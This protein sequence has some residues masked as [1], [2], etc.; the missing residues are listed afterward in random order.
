MIS[1]ITRKCDCSGDTIVSGPTGAQA[2][3]K[4]GSGWSVC[5]YADTVVPDQLVTVM[6]TP[7]DS[8]FVRQ[9]V[10]S[11]HLDGSFHWG[12]DLGNGFWWFYVNGKKVDGSAQWRPQVPTG[13]YEIDLVFWS[14]CDQPE[15]PIKYLIHHK[16]G[17][18]AVDVLQ[19][20]DGALKKDVVSLG[21]YP[22]DSGSYVEVTDAIGDTPYPLVLCGNQTYYENVKVDTIT[23]K[24]IE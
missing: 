12:R 16:D 24:Q 20:F 10:N 15:L 17:V 4:Q 19:C 23:F 6:V 21:V 13:S 18:S 5:E 11:E 14:F 7:D 1:F 2:C 3:N 9:C 8:G 22:L